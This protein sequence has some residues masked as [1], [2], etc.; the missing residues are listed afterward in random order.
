[1]HANGESHGRGRE[2]KSQRESHAVVS[3]NR[4]WNKLAPPLSLLFLPNSSIIHQRIHDPALLTERAQ[5]LGI[6]VETIQARGVE[7]NVPVVCAPCSGQLTLSRTDPL[8]IP[9][10]FWSQSYIDSFKYGASPHGGA[11]VGLER[12]VMLF[13][14]MRAGLSAG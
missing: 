5:A 4:S 2:G 3:C 6:P 7:G 9:L 11:G 14:G 12:V 13:C 1:M 8:L 10:P